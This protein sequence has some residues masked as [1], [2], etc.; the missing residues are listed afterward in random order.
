MADFRENTQSLRAS[1]AFTELGVNMEMV[2]HF[3]ELK[4]SMLEYFNTP[5]FSL[6]TPLAHQQPEFLAGCSYNNSFSNF[7]TDSRIVVPRVRTVRGNEDVL[8]ESSR[9][10]VTEQSTSISKT[11]CSSASTSETQGDT[12]KNKKIRSRRGKKVSSNEKEEGN[13]ERIIHVR[14]KRGQ[15]TD[16]H[17][18]AE[19]VRREKINKKMRCLQDLVP[20]CHKDMGMAGM[21]EEIIN[22]VHSLQNQVEFLSMELAAACSSNDLNIETESSRKTQGTNSHEAL[23][24]EIWA[25]EAY[26]EYTS[27]HSTWSL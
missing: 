14:A 19:R 10:E 2:K 21:L 23:E 3:A 1:Q 17:S 12:Y 8:Y 5:N 7:Q 11:M 27:F 18:I 24:M 16:S 20:G 26:G 4:P 9:R 13:P 6:A 15:A 22:Y 25:K